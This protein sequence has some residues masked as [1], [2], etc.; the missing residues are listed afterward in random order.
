MKERAGNFSRK[1]MEKM[2]I[3]RPTRLG[4]RFTGMFSVGYITINMTIIH[5]LCFYSSFLHRDGGIHVHHRRCKCISK[6]QGLPRP[7][8]EFLWD[9]EA[10]RASKREPLCG[11]V[12]EEHPSSKGCQFHMLNSEGKLQGCTAEEE[13]PNR[14]QQRCIE[15][16]ENWTQVMLSFLTPTPQVKTVI[17]DILM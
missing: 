16:E 3:S 7:P 10:E 8:G 11:R 1:E 14:S 2:L 9:A 12:F 5:T 13:S 6:Q 15:E 4:L 17:C